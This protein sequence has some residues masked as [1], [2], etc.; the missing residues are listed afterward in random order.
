M[1]T[2]TILITIGFL[3]TLGCLTAFNYGMKESYL[4]GTYKSRFKDM[5]FTPAKGIENIDLQSANLLGAGIE[6]GE[7]EGVW[8]GKGVKN[9]ILLE[10]KQHTLTL[11]LTA[12]SKMEGYRVWNND[13]IIVTKT[14]NSVVA[15]PYFKNKNS[16]GM[17]DEGT[18]LKG[19]HQDHLDLQIGQSVSITLNDLQLNT[20]KAT[21]GDKLKGGAKLVLSSNIKIN[22]A[23]INV[24]GASSL[25]LLGPEIIKASYSLSDSATVS[26]FG[27]TVKMIK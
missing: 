9:N 2:S 24:P 11:D 27:K 3:F 7:K 8:I 21:V 12:K 26:L 25:L 1:K 20:L 13:I 18:S 19:F 15:V 5:D 16:E 17:P 14:L 10:I 4:A 22:T 23:V 6:Y